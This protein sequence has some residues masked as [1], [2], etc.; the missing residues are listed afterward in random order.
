MMQN[1]GEILVPAHLRGVQFLFGD[2]THAKW[3]TNCVRSHQKVIAVW[4]QE[5]RKERV[6]N[7]RKRKRLLQMK[8]QSLHHSLHPRSRVL[9]A[10]HLRFRYLFSSS[11]S[12][13]LCGA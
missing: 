3:V 4:E 5:G 11:P 7:E 9:L 13:S 10:L 2:N 1:E 6:D 8:T 12:A